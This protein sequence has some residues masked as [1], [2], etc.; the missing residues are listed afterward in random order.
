MK[1]RNRILNE[2]SQQVCGWAEATVVAA[3]AG[4]FRDELRRVAESLRRIDLQ[5][6]SLKWDL[7]GWLGRA[8]E[9]AGVGEALRDRSAGIR[10][11][12][13]ALS[14]G[15]RRLAVGGCYAGGRNVTPPF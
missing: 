5:V 6:S 13:W 12:R 8:G 4:A 1:Q 15:F 9:G 11:G 3:V 14:A 10:R 7:A 2:T